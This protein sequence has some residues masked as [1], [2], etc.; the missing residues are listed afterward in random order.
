LLTSVP[1]FKVN[2]G[3]P[4]FIPQDEFSFEPVSLYVGEGAKT[5]LMPS[6]E[7]PDGQKYKIILEGLSKII[8]FTKY[9]PGK[10]FVVRPTDP[11]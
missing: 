2:M 3:P 8:A 7:E 5:V 11:S 6:I 9:D 4:S 10:S 1:L